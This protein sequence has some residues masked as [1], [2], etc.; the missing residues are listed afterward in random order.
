VAVF[1]YGAAT[2][3]GLASWA[4]IKTILVLA[5]LAG[6][7][8]AGQTLLILM[9]GFD[10]S[11]SGFIVASALTVTTLKDK[12]GLSFP[13]AVLLAV[14]GAGIAGAASGQVCHRYNIQPLIVTL[15]MGTIAVGLI[16]VQT[17]G[18]LA[19]SAPAS[20]ARLTSPASDTFGIDIPP[21]PVIWAVVAVCFAWFL[22]R[23]AGGR[24]LLATGANPR[25]AVY[26]LIN[27]RKVWTLAFA[28][29]AIASVLVGLLVGGFA[30]AV[31]GRVGDPY[32]FQS[33]IAVIVGG[34]AFGGPGDYSRTVVG[35]LFVTVVTTVLVGHGA[36]SADQQIIYGIAILL[37]VSL[38]GRERRLRDRI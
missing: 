12:Y 10:L 9:G 19:G 5:S 29:S 6:L 22:H 17:G 27:T 2:L 13:V 37:A 11:V 26:S 34:T 36:D 24:R 31:D 32:L 35:A 8:S 21:L 16:Q 25:A 7:A 23:T 28:F 4:S 15:A 33:V 1:W 38:Y 18:T 14:V 30:G 20:L 3:E